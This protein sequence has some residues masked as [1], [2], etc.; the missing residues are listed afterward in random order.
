VD[1][2]YEKDPFSDAFWTLLAV[3]ESKPPETDP[4]A[5]PKQAVAEVDTLMPCED[6]LPSDEADI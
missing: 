2:W 1:T 6:K 4:E 3:F 5:S